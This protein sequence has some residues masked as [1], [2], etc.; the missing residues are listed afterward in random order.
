MTSSGRAL[1]T[2][3]P[4]DRGAVEALVLG[5]EMGALVTFEGR[6][7]NHDP[8]APDTVDRLDYEAHPDAQRILEDILAEFARV[9]TDD[10]GELRIAAHHRIGT[11]A[12]EDTAL[13]VS[14][15]AAHRAD[16]FEVCRDVVE[17]IKARVPIWKK[18]FSNNEGSWVGLS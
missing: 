2:E 10:G 9:A 7:R 18:Q 1:I 14:V 5:P 11:L 13:L 12:V 6:V 16:T 17:Q 4:L 15:T 3:L 8:E